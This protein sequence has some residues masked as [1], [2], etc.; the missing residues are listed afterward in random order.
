MAGQRSAVRDRPR[1]SS[2]SRRPSSG[3]R[4]GLSGAPEPASLTREWVPLAVVLLAAIAIRVWL[5]LRTSGLTMDSPLYVRMAEA[6]GRSAEVLGPAH[7]GYPAFI[8]IAGLV[9]PGQEWPGRIVS[10]VASLI[11]VGVTY[12]LGRRSLP[13]WG[14][15][16]AAGLVAVHR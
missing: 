15:A 12:A 13:P 2:A 7:H 1:T 8:A 14:A 9:I 11:L 4:T 6:L 3:R 10:M 16:A 5:A